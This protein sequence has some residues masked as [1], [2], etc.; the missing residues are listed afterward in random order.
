MARKPADQS[1]NRSDIIQAAA[2]VLQR[3][4]YEAATMKDIAAAVNLT[5]ASLYHH[6]RNKDSLLLAVLE[7]GLDYII[8][9]VEP[10]VHNDQ[11]VERKL[12][13]MTR[14]HIIGLT[15]NTAVGAAMVFEIRALMNVKAPPPGA[16]PAE[17]AA[18]TEFIARRDAF[19]AR[20]D[21]FEDLFVQVIRAGVDQGVLR[22]I[23]IDIFAKT[24]LGAHNWVGVWYRPDGRLTGEQIADAIADTLLRGVMN[25]P[26]A[27]PPASA[28][29]EAQL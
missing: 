9:Q 1:V 25:Q 27:P 20:R 12:R 24:L 13:A 10:I 18:Y 15:E 11:P 7:V 19:F 23:D 29:R 14:E 17:K 22:P 16:R 26:P 5:A 2:E 21:E 28:H 8:Q 4:G 6:F 3:S